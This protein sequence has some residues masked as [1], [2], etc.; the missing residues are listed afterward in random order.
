MADDVA[1][2]RPIAEE[3]ATPPVPTAAAPARPM[4][5]RAAPA[6]AVQVGAAATHEQ[7]EHPVRSP[8]GV[9]GRAT[10][11]DA[12]MHGN[13]LAAAIEQQGRPAP[14]ERAQHLGGAAASAASGQATPLDSGA[15][16]S[17]TDEEEGRDDPLARVSAI[18][19]DPRRHDPRTAEERQADGDDMGA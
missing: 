18:D 8:G 19:E 12:A 15:A 16:V 5:P 11:H 4:P 9:D 3:P 7:I 6:P 14:S 13:R 2:I 17:A 1:P 10:V